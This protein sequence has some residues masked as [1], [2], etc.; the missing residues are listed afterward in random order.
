LQARAD[1]FLNYDGDDNEDDDDD[2][3]ADLPWKRGHALQTPT[4]PCLPYW[5]RPYSINM[6]GYPAANIASR[7][8]MRK[9]PS[10]HS[11]Q[12]MV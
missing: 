8:G 2:D 6:R 7:Y 11:K 9:A 10:E 1:S 5:P 4:T 12:Q 3:N